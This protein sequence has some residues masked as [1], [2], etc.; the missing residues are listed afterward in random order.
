M[1]MKTM[2]GF[3]TR[4]GIDILTLLSGGEFQIKSRQDC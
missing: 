4:A 1:G 3:P 2:A